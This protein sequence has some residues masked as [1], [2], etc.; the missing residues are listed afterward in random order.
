MHTPCQVHG[1]LLQRGSHR[2][3]RAPDCPLGRGELGKDREA[4]GFHSSSGEARRTR[5]FRVDGLA[6]MKC[7]YIKALVKFT[8]IWAHILKITEVLRNPEGRG[9]LPFLDS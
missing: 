9:L 4:L 2:L 8:G 7:S 5:E 1:A 6:N 3:T